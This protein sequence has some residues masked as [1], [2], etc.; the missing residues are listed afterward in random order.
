MAQPCTTAAHPWATPSIVLVPYRRHMRRIL[1]GRYRGQDEKEAG[2]Q[3]A[4]IRMPSDHG[5]TD[6]HSFSWTLYI[7]NVLPVDHLVRYHCYFPCK[8]IFAHFSPIATAGACRC[9]PRTR[10]RMDVSATRR[11]STPYTLNSS[12]TTPPP[13]AS[14]SGAMRH[15]D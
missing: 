2:A 5:H 4:V 11:F 3:L 9:V 7:S 1:M 15:V 12:S 8:I 6:M 10:G 13:S 14:S